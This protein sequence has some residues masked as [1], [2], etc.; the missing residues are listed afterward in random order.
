[1]IDCCCARLSGTASVES[2]RSVRGMVL[3]K[4]WRL[5]PS[6]TM[7]RVITALFVSGTRLFFQL[8]E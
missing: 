5:L 3:E 1:M 4:D 2:I 6:K 8:L 7:S